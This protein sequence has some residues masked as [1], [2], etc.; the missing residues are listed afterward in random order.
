M[1]HVTAFV[2]LKPGALPAALDA[3]RALVPDVL[4]KEPGC[5]EYSPTFDLDLGLPIQDQD[6]NMIIVTERWM[7]ADDFKAHV[8]GPPHVLT[9]RAAMKDCVEH[10]RVRITQDAI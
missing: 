10:T 4:A 3:Y 5:L 8:N 2:T 1:I 7:S 6:P 9:F